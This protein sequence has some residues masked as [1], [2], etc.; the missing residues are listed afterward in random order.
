MPC[1]RLL[2]KSTRFNPRSRTGSDVFRR[3]VMRSWIVSI[4]APARG[5]TS[6]HGC[7]R[8]R[9]AGFNPRSRTGSD[10]STVSDDF[11]VVLFQSTLPHGERQRP[12]PYSD[13]LTRFQS[14]LPHGERPVP[15]GVYRVP[16]V[17]SIHAPARGATRVRAAHQGGAQVS[18]HAPARG[19]TRPTISPTTRRFGFQSTLPHG[20]RPLCQ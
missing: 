15:C 2:T 14:T 4:H 12:Q 9:A 11:Q 6:A 19:A 1:W 20:E 7:G 18:I 8:L 10:L 17:V 13:R 5:A 3:D 16:G